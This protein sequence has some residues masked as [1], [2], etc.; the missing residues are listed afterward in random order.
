MK[1]DKKDISVLTEKF[2][3]TTGFVPPIPSSEK[4]V[5]IDAKTAQN[6]GSTKDSDPTM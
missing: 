5:E 2:A 3:P 4:E 6:I 1:K